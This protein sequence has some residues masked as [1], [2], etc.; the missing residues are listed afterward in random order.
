MTINTNRRLLHALFVIRDAQQIRDRAAKNGREEPRGLR[1]CPGVAFE[2]AGTADLTALLQVA[3]CKTGRHTR[4]SQPEERQI[5]LTHQMGQRRA[6][7]GGGQP[8]GKSRRL[9]G[10][11]P[12]GIAISS[13]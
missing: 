13:P 2:V 9:S 7:D 8:P 6:V 5:P 10:S 4:G 11:P 12:P 1:R 3:L